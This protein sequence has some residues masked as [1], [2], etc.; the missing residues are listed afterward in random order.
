MKKLFIL[1]LALILVFGLVACKTNEEPVEE[2]Q[3]E[4]AKP[5]EEEEEAE[6]YT[7]AIIVKD[8]VSPFWTYLITGAEL[9]AVEL[10]C[11]VVNY[12]PIQVQNAEEQFRQVEDAIQAGV[13]AICIAAIDKD[14]IVP[15]IE[16]ANAAG[17]PVISTNSKV[18]GGKIETFVGVDNYAGAATLAEFMVKELDGKGKVVILEGNPAGQTSQD[19][20]AGFVD[21]LEKYPNIEILVSQPAMFQRAEAMTV[22]ENILQSEDQI[23]AV[24]AMNDEMALGAFQALNDA[25][26]LE[27]VM[28]TGF[29]GALEGLEAIKAGNIHASLNQA[30]FDQ[31]GLA[32]KAAGSYIK[33]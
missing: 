24:L 7:I 9:M 33:R 6:P 13:D 3:V 25:G 4:E 17:I 22:M 15:A 19:R 28:I 32:V 5:A 26:R 2:K 27:G 16:K 21:V 14:G 8:S 20:V 1:M 11:E 29:D 18:G 30:P 31:G 10:G 23:D 12:S